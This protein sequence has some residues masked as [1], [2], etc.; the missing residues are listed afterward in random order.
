MEKLPFNII[1]AMTE[2]GGIGSKEKLPWTFKEDLQH[3]RDITT[4]VSNKEKKNICIMGRKTF[5]SIGKPLENR[6]NFVLTNQIHHLIARTNNNLFYVSSFDQIYR[7]L[8][9]DEW[10]WKNKWETIFVIGGAEIYDLSFKQS[11]FQCVKMFVT[12]VYKDFQCD[13]FFPIK[14]DE[15]QCIECEKN[16]SKQGF[17]Y[18]FKIYSIIEKNIY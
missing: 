15:K 12:I 14:L 11:L 16:I 2:N 6:I 7:I 13:Q 9:Q 3:F 10:E 18:E 1:V 4:S 17:P 5:Y 8:H